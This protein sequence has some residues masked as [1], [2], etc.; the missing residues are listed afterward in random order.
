MLCVLSFSLSASPPP[1]QARFGLKEH[2]GEP[3]DSCAV[4]SGLGGKYCSRAAEQPAAFI[5]TSVSFY[6]NKNQEKISEF[7]QHPKGGEFFTLH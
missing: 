3:R 5:L 2:S 7:R 6:G 4:L 1:A